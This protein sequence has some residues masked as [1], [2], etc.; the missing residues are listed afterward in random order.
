PFERGDVDNL[1]LQAIAKA[2]VSF[3]DPVRDRGK[4]G[5]QVRGQCVRALF[6][7]DTLADVDGIPHNLAVLTVE[8]LGGRVR[9]DCNLHGDRKAPIYHAHIT[10]ERGWWV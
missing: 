10:K 4:F 8:E 5:L 2:L 1:E 6:G 7:A 3:G 9:Q